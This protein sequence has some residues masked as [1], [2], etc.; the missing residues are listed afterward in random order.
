M[1]SLDETK[2]TLQRN[3]QSQMVQKEINNLRTKAKIQ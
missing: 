2:P 1:P 3:L